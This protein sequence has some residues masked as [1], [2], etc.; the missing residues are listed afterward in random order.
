MNL[1]MGQ[2]NVILKETNKKSVTDKY[3][4][5]VIKREVEF[6]KETYNRAYNDFSHFIAANPSVEKMVA[7]EMCIRDSTDCNRSEY[8]CY[9]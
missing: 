5:A 6:S 8:R 9:G 4:V 3:K 7:N 2:A 1:P